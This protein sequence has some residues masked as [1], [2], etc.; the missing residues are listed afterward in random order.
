[1]SIS[2]DMINGI[3]VGIE[4]L[5]AGEDHDQTIIVDLFV[6]RLLFQWS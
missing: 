1:M 2:L 3:S 5:P 6:I 4:Y